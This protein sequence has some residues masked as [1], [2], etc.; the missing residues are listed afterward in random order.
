MFLSNIDF[1]DESLSVT[2]S[3]DDRAIHM[4]CNNFFNYVVSKTGLPSRRYSYGGQA[5]RDAHN[6]VHFT[7]AAHIVVIVLIL[8]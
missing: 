7:R 4:R 8:N 3:G 1:V 5:I 2:A 6:Y